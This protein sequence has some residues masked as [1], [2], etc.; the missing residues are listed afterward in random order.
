VQGFFFI[1]RPLKVRRVVGDLA[2]A[3]NQDFVDDNKQTN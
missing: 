1:L 3:P 2:P